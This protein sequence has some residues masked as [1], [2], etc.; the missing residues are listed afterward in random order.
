MKLRDYIPALRFGAKIM[1]EDVAGMIGLPY[2]GNIFY[3]DSN[4]G[5]D[6][7]N[8]GLSQN[9]ALKTVAAAYAK[10]T[11]GN[12]DVVLLAPSGGTGRTA[13]TTAITWGKRFTHLIGNAAPSAQT[14]RAGMS[15]S[16]TAGTSVGSI[17]FSENGCIIK[18][19]ALTTSDDN[20]SFVTVTGDYN[21]FLGV[22]FKGATNATTGDDAAARALVLTGAEEN[23]FGGCTIG[24]DTYSR[25]TTNASLE[26]TAASARNVFEDCLF[27]I[28]ADNAGALFFKAAS[29]ADI[30]RFVHFKNCMF[31]NAAYSAS[32]T[33]T[34]A[35]SIHAAV[36]GSVI[37]DGCS[38]LGVT[39]WS[40]DY[41]ALVACNNPKVTASNS[42]FM[43][44]VTT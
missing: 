37:L 26:M 15:F 19:I 28:H 1:P 20:N 4:S 10:C 42:G 6:T 43:E 41:T 23:Y 8:G 31:H 16:G 17:T 34:T 36:G 12:H 35:F 32:T 13:E 29:A 14:P 30:D 21:S 39:D 2:I 27:P 44:S 9:N 18:N 40:T 22:D 7:T 5:N 38:V 11:S 25:S 33:L 24:S 3:V